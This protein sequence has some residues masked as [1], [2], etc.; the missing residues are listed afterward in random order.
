MKADAA[1]CWG[2]KLLFVRL[3]WDREMNSGQAGWGLL[4][5]LAG[6]AVFPSL[7]G[8]GGGVHAC[9][10]LPPAEVWW[11][12]GREVSALLGFEP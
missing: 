10:R 5:L 4:S 7:P 6:L 2:M 3:C 8:G 9:P 11:G 12:R 1:E